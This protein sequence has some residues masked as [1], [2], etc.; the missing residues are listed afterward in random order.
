MQLAF[1][2]KGRRASRIKCKE[3]RENEV[4]W[5]E[6]ASDVQ[7]ACYQKCKWHDV[8]KYVWMTVLKTVMNVLQ[9]CHN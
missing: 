1:N 4:G 6:S 3:Q 9:A 2:Q 8:C 7:M 5:L